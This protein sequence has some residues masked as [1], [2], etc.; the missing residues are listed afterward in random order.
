MRRRLQ[1]QSASLLPNQFV[2]HHRGPMP[3]PADVFCP[4]GIWSNFIQHC[5]SLCADKYIHQYDWE[6]YLTTAPEPQPYAVAM[7]TRISL[8]QRRQSQIRLRLLAIGQ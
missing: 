3:L 5:A 8:C 6:S 1:R 4:D 2:K 7:R